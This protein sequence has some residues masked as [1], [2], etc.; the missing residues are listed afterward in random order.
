MDQ[1]GIPIAHAAI[2]HT[3]G[4]QRPRHIWES[5][6]EQI[7]ATYIDSKQHHHGLKKGDNSPKVS[8]VCP[9][10]KKSALNPLQ[11]YLST[12]P[13]SRER[14]HEIDKSKPK[15]GKERILLG[16]PRKLEDRAR[17]KRNDVDSTHLLR[18]HHDEGRECRAAHARDREKLEETREI[19]RAAEDGVFLLELG[20]DL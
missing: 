14:K 8:I 7:P 10:K 20:V 11:S 12:H 2:A 15:A 6:E 17:V 18:D 5:K 13:N 3:G 9:T 16:V 4:K 19:V 1:S